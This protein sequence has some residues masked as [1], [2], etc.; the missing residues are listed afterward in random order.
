MAPCSLICLAV[1]LLPAVAV[2]LAAQ[3]ASLA[4]FS[5]AL[6][7]SL[8][9]IDIL[10]RM[11]GEEFAVLLPNTSLEESALLAERVRQTIASTPFATVGGVLTITICVCF[12]DGCNA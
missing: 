6:N 5:A 4:A 2:A 9:E 12:K 11:G 8:R 10:G 1:I 3:N 7:S